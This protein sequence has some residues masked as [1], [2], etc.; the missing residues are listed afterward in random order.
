MTSPL[1]ALFINTSLKKEPSESHTK[2]LMNASAAIMEGEGVEVDAALHR[3]VLPPPEELRSEVQRHLA[4]EHVLSQDELEGAEGGAGAAQVHDLGARALLLAHLQSQ[5]G[6]A[7]AHL[8]RFNYF[9]RLKPKFGRN[10]SL[11]Y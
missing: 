8:H 10:Y 5:G 11:A 4:L 1:K 6:E 9:S 7:R 2:L 3:Q